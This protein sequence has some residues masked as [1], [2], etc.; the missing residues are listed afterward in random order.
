M[1]RTFSSE[2][3]TFTRDFHLIFHVPICTS[4]SRREK[5][6]RD[7]S[8][9]HGRSQWGVIHILY[10]SFNDILLVWHFCELFATHVCSADSAASISVSFRLMPDTSSIF[11]CPTNMGLHKII[12]FRKCQK[13]GDVKLL[14]FMLLIFLFFHF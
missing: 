8:C 7:I 12:V 5:T 6:H 2:T 13:E 11:S 10:K 9:C 14:N 1:L 3:T 4:N